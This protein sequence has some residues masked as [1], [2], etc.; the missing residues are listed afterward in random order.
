M[1][2]NYPQ[3]TPPTPPPDYLNQISPQ[4]PRRAP[5][6]LGLKQ[7]ILLGIAL[8][9]VMIA[10]VTLINSIASSGRAPL[11][12]LS[13]QL[14]ATE[15]VATAA[16]TNLKS[17]KLRSLNSNLKI[18]LTNTNRDA[19]APLLAAGIDV[20]KPSKS[21][22]AQESTTALTAALEDARLNGVYDRTYAR[23]MAFRLGN[24]LTLMQ[25]ALASARGATLKV[26]LQSSYDNLKPTQVA[27]A[28]Y[29]TAE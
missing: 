16:Q 10:L 29:G 23:E 19:V 20:K 2:P 18:Y 28:D 26:F 13:V 7:V 4:A 1:Y 27:F 3:Q 12:H 24:H 17:S 6:H 5:F 25:Q 14:T 15:V 9:V 11:E 8:V 22:V 21:I